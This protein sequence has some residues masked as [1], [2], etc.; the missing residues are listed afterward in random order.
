MN[1]KLTRWIGTVAALGALL[2]LPACDRDDDDDHEDMAILQ[3]LDQTQPGQPVVA[4]WTVQGGW[5][6]AL[7]DLPLGDEVRLS[8]GLVV[9]ADDGD[10][11]TL[12]ENGE[13]WMQYWLAGNAPT[14][15]IDVGRDDL[16]HGDHVHIYGASV[17]TTQIQFELWHVDH[18]EA[19]TSAIDVNVVEDEPAET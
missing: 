9:M 13:F 4:T 6:G 3:V 15:I 1:R 17:G 7:P 2:A 18:V 19:A 5:T 10:Q 14:G 16:F 8:L 11:L 12:E